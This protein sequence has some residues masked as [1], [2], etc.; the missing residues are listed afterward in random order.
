MSMSKMI[1]IGSFLFAIVVTIS[2]AQPATR[3]RHWP[4]RN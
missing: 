3:G 1:R 2:F 4:G